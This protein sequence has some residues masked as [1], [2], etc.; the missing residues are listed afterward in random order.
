LEEPHQDLWHSTY[1]Q[2]LRKKTR[3][4]SQ[5]QEA[6]KKVT[7]PQAIIMP[8]TTKQVETTAYEAVW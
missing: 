3:T 4:W 5:N 1:H 8:S 7:L 2:D 6:S